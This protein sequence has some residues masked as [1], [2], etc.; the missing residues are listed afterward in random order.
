[1]SD[2]TGM[3]TCATHPESPAV[4]ECAACGRAICEFCRAKSAQRPLCYPCA[5]L[6]E[7]LPEEEGEEPG[8]PDPG[9][10]G[11]VG[12][13]RVIALVGGAALIGGFLWGKLVSALGHDSYYFILLAG[14]G[15]GVLTRAAAPL[16]RAPLLP[17][18]AVVLT[19]LCVAVHRTVWIWDVLREDR[20]TRRYLDRTSLT[21]TVFPLL[22]ASVEGLSPEGWV[23]VVLAL[24]VSGFFC[25]A[26][27]RQPHPGPP[28]PA[29]EAEKGGG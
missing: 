20:T 15:I 3:P 2:K 16:A 13:L 29:E 5:A 22:G 27:G 24:G 11:P 1:M 19:A 14:A 4:A 12:Y 25:Y 6:E 28:Q 10:L 18:V 9:T 26:A 23:F 17:A 7:P 8:S 21:Q